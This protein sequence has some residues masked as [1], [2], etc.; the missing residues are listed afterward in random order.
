MYRTLSYGRARGS[1]IV[2]GGADMVNL[3]SN[4]YLA[5]TH[6]TSMESHSPSSRLVSGNDVEYMDLERRLAAHMG[7]QSSL[8]YPTGYMAVLGCVPALAVPG[9][10]ILSD[11]LNHASIIDACRLSGARVSIYGHNDMDDLKSKMKTARGTTLVIT[12]GIF[13]MDGDY[14]RLAEIAELSFRYGA[15]IILDDAHGDFVAGDGRGTAA[16]FGAVD[17][18]C[19]TVSSLSKALGAFGG[20]VATSREIVD[21]LVNKSRPLIYTSALPPGVIRDIR[22]RLDRDLASRRRILSRNVRRMALGLEQ[23]GLCQGAQT[24]IIPVVVG[25]ES[26]A[27]A[28]S[29]SLAKH[30]VFARA[31]RY[32]TVP[33][34]AARIR[35]SI[36][37]ALSDGDIDAT[38]AAFEAAL[39][40]TH[41][42]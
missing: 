10:T 33:R 38:L 41:L 37:A 18:V 34:H 19:V 36:T 17:R 14:S 20:Y 15:Y 8:V 3:G 32:P 2:V 27:V 4:D 42:S 1:H 22:G 13:S 31:I 12:E 11:E 16:M 29:D 24:H 25:G 30:G 35:V 21:F 40:E 26:R 5:I 6:R 9:Y 39:R 28:M 23:L 7:T